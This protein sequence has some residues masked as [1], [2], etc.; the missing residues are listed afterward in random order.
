MLSDLSHGR[1]CTYAPNWPGVAGHGVL[2]GLIS[3]EEV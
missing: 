1:G 2:D 3:G